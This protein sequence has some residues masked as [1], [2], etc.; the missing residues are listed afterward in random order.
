V[1]APPRYATPRSPDRR[2]FGPAIG[3]VAAA[4]GTPLMPWQQLVADVGNELLPDGTWAY[5]LVIVTIQRQ[6]GKTTLLGPVNLH[7]AAT[8]PRAKCWLTAQSRQDARDTMMDVVARVTGS[9]LAGLFDV[10]RSNGSE[11]LT[12][13]ATGS[14]F[15]VF[16]PTEDAL[17]GKANELVNVDEAWAFD[18]A[19]GAALEQAILPTFTTTGGQLWLVSTAGHGR[20][21]WLRE[22]VERG[23]AA[24]ES[25]R[26]EGIAYFEWALDPAHAS[27]V[28]AGVGPDVDADTR[29][30]AVELVLAAHPAA[31]ITLRPDALAGAMDA[32]SPGEF[33]RAYGNVWTAAAD[34]AIAEHLWTGCANTVPWVPPQPGLVALAFDVASDRRDAA[35]VAAWRDTDTGPVRLDV[36]DAHPGDSWLVPRLRELAARWRPQ[37][38]GYDQVGPALDV[39]DQL[40]RGG[41]ELRPTSSR[42]YAAACAGFLSAVT[43]SQLVHRSQVALDDAVAAA[44]TRPM[45]DGAWAWS[46][47]T[48]T[49]TIA[50]LVAATVAAWAYD[51]R[52][53]PP[54]RPVVAVSRA[55]SGRPA[56]RARSGRPVS[57]RV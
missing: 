40:Q 31:G 19:Q 23:R 57:S 3:K 17:H 6:G 55:A 34:R 30:R 12:C 16:A 46:R 4:Q 32:M 2:T 35:I 21:T 25:G 29:A 51:H 14:T 22:Y 39:A 28:A 44:A 20:S 47:R 8:R 43:N 13:S 11:G 42:E 33:L 41:L 49:A 1:T 15:R 38:I 54:V 36:V 10:R 24:V 50:P 9:P 5:R 56:A 26:R 18:A 52:P 27:T 45:G 53:A 37:A 48:S 7:R